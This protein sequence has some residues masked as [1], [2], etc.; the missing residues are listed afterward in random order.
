MAEYEKDD[1]YDDSEADEPTEQM[2]ERMAGIRKR[3]KTATE[4]ERTLR[5][6]ARDDFRF[7]WIQGNQ[8]NSDLGDKRGAGRPRYEFNKLGSAIKQVVND[9]RQNTP[10]IKV[11]AN[12]ESTRDMAEIRQGLIKNIESM[13]NA[14]SVY[15]WAALY[16]IT[17][18]F[19]CWT[20]STK[21]VQQDSFEQDIVIERVTDPFSVWFDASAHAMNR[22]DARYAFIESRVTRSAFKAKYPDAAMVDF[23]S[24]DVQTG[25][26]RDWCGE[27]D[28]R[29]AEYWYKES[30]KKTI[31]QLSDG[32]VVDA[33]EFD[34]LKDAAANPPIDPQTGQ[35]IGP[36]V[37]IANKRTVTY[38]KV[39]MEIVSGIEVLEGPYDWAGRYIPIVPVWG[40][41]VN[42]DGHD[43]WYGM[44]R[45]SRDA[46][47]LYNYNRS[48]MVEV[49]ANQSRAPY[50]Y[51]PKM[52]EGF[53]TQW[54]R[55]AVDNAPGLPFN[56]DP[57]VAGGAPRRE[58]PPQFPAAMLTAA[59]VDAEDIKAT[60]GIYDA[61]LG[62]RSN[63]TSGKAI[64]ARQREGDTATYDYADNI[65]KAIQWTGIIIDDL[66]PHIYDTER[67][68]RI[69]GADGAEN[70]VKVNQ[71]VFNPDATDP[72]TGKPGK[73]ERL[74]DLS[75]GQ[76]DVTVTVG[77]SYATQRMETLDA[78][79]QLAG[80]GGPTALIAMYGAVKNMDAPG[81]QEV[82]KA[83]RKMLVNQGQLEPDQDDPPP[84][85]PQP[86]PADVA[87][88]QKDASTAQ[89]NQAKVALTQAQT[90]QLVATTPSQVD[91]N[92]AEAMHTATK[93]LIDQQYFK[94][95]ETEDRYKDA[96][97]NFA[98]TALASG[99]T[100]PD[101]N[102]GA[103]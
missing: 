93:G 30:A 75:T 70:Y 18:G 83:L 43:E 35:P 64:Q 26:L 40:N 66:I 79:M 4:G 49:L 81:M 99:Q 14:D 69:L 89:L 16:A 55:M 13:S 33:T 17:S 67:E 27:K 54:S 11:R 37:T 56:P 96:V 63:E 7:A 102:F 59:Q 88:A 42:V 73:W 8:W 29:V 71:D 84:P 98:A 78:M 51:T 52:T 92:Q 95:K 22:E 46:Q 101:G 41:L 50:L 87:A 80:M 60:T 32:R 91:K 6:M 82:E 3:F 103:S 100:A 74:N 68:I 21:Y 61:S 31:Y 57:S 94:R 58:P 34:P 5:E 90:Q 44:V 97:D 24:A 45:M 47:M 39:K 48:T 65:A 38:D 62:Q 85:P 23:K 36:A 76:Y 72:L 12:K 9:N 15:D 28:V 10:N 53:E 2:S 77:P 25:D 1:A 86:N 20:V 19:G